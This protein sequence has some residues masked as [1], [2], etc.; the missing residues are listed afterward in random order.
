[1]PG[2]AHRRGFGYVR[3]LPNGRYQASYVGPDTLRHNAPKTFDAKAD[4]EVWLADEKRLIG[5]GTWTSPKQRA[6]ARKT[7]L[8]FET[9]S[10]AWLRDR[11]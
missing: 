5:L 7:K 6:A 10:D 8:T 1:M 3:K 9:Y 2:R 11:T 4:A